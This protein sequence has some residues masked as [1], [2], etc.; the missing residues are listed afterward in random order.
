[1]NILVIEDRRFLRTALERTLTKA[2]YVVTAVANGEEGLEIARA[3][4]PGLIFLDMMLPG[5]DGT[6]VLKALKKD[7]STTTIPVIVL[8]ELSQRNETKLKE[9]GAAS[10]IQKAALDLQK[11]SD[12]LMRIIESALNP[13]SESQDA[14][15]QQHLPPKQRSDAEPAGVNSSEA[16]P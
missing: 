9:A 2:G 4:L 5:L 16:L 6:C 7:A 1:M 14:T 8:T 10:Y 3:S 15:K 11:S 13:S 12:T